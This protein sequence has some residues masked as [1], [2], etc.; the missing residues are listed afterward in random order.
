MLTTED[1]KIIDCF[2]FIYNCPK[3]VKKEEV[4]LTFDLNGVKSGFAYP[5]YSHVQYKGR[6]FDVRLKSL[7]DNRDL[8]KSWLNE[9]AH[10]FVHSIKEELTRKNVSV[11]SFILDSYNKDIIFDFNINFNI[12]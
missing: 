10:S 11:E 12:S 3:E 8:P 7:L 5:E 2:T 6:L 9:Y 4:R 1:R